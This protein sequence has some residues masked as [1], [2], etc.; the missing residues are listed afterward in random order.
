MTVLE[1]IQKL[2]HDVNSGALSKLPL[3]VQLV[4]NEAFV[5][6]PIFAGGIDEK[7]PEL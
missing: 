2:F 4:N 7:F 5:S 1:N 6:F 3:E